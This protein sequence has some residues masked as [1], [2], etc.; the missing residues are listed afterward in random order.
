MNRVFYNRTVGIFVLVTLLATSLMSAA[1]NI[2]EGGDFDK[3]G[4][5]GLPEGPSWAWKN[6]GSDDLKITFSQ[7]EKFS[8]ISS[9]HLLDAN[10][11]KFNDGL[12]WMMAGNR[13]AQWHGKSL[14]LSCM[15]KQIKSSRPKGIGIA[16]WL[17]CKD[18]KIISA[19][20]GPETI[21]ETI[22]QKYE[23]TIDV[24]ENA[25]IFQIFLSCANGWGNDGE[26]YFDELTLKP[27]SSTSV[28]SSDSASAIPQYTPA[29]AF[30]F[31]DGRV[32]PLWR[33]QAWGDLY[34]EERQGVQFLEV[35]T[36]KGS[37]PN[38]GIALSSPY[39]NRVVDL[40]GSTKD[41]E[42][43]LTVKPFMRFQVNLANKS[44]MVDQT[45]IKEVKDGW[46]VVRIPM[47]RFGSGD[48]LKGIESLKIQFP[49]AMAA[50]TTVKIGRI[51]VSGVEK[52]VDIKA[53]IPDLVNQAEQLCKGLDK[54]WTTDD[55]RRP[56]IKNG[57][58]YANDVPVFF[59]GPWI[60]SMLLHADF[61]PGSRRDFLKDDIYNR[62]FDDKIAKNLGVNSFQ[63]SS[64]T[65][66]PSYVELELPWDKRMLENAI[67]AAKLY[68][69]T[70]GMPFILDFAW[71]NRVA[72][73][74]VQ[75]N[76]GNK[77]LLH[78]NTGWHEFIPLC[79]EHQDAIKIYT[80][81][82][83]TGVAFALAN[84]ANPFIYEIFNESSYM[85]GCEFNRKAFA[86]YLQQRFKTVSSI[87]QSMGISITSFE[88]LS[89][90]PRYEV[91]PAL[92]VEWCKFMSRR[93]AAILRQYAK[94][95][96]EVDRRHNVYITEQLWVPSLFTPNGAGMDYRL[97][98]D[99]LDVLTIEGGRHFG[100]LSHNNSNPMEAAMMSPS[101]PFVADFFAALSKGAK[102]VV[103]SEHYC[104]RNYFGK[105]VPS[106]KEDLITAMWSEVF[107]GM[108]GS[109]TYA[110]CKRIWEWKNLKEAK[111]TVYDGGYK[112]SNMLNP[113]SWPREALDGFKVFSGELKNL[114]EIALPQPRQALGTVALVYSYPSLRMSAVNRENI[115]KQ[116]L[117]SY[118][119]LI[120]KQYPVEIVFA[121]DIPKGVLKRFNAVVLPAIR[122]T[123]SQTVES[124]RH[125]VADGGLVVCAGN[126]LSEDEYGRPL[127]ASA[128]LGL[129]RGN[130][131]ITSIGAVK[132]ENWWSYRIGKGS[133]TYI[134]E[135][136]ATPKSAGLISDILAANNTKR[137]FTVNGSSP[138][139]LTQVELRLIDR[140]DT[141]LLL[142][143][144]WEDQ[145]SR[146]VRLRYAGVETLKPM[147]I[148]S[149]VTCDL[150]LNESSDKWDDAT[151][152][153]RG[154]DVIL[155]PQTRVLL[156]LT[157]RITDKS[158]KRVSPQDLNAEF[159]LIQTENA[160]AL[161]DANSQ[162][163]KLQDEYHA[164]R[165]YPD[166][167][168]ADCIPIN[169]ARHV[170]VGFKDELSGDRK[171]GWFDQ[172]SNDYSN[173][174]IG[175]VILAGVPFNIIA[176]ENNQGNSVIVMR[177]KEWPYVSGINDIPVNLKAKNLYILHTAG[178]T[179]QPGSTCYYLMV[180][181]TDGDSLNIP[182]RFDYEIGGWW[183][184][185]PLPYAKIA[186]ETSNAIC[187]RVGLYCW[188]WSNPTPDKEIASI[189]MKGGGDNAVP[190]IVA[191]SAEK[192]YTGTGK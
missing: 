61:G 60:D 192:Y 62:V 111:D 94:V 164:A 40:S 123:D 117:N 58:F 75:E 39:A 23:L 32:L 100:Q 149:P 132:N 34:V 92:W 76:S 8:G 177:G 189:D 174:P 142:L 160:K 186:H 165:K 63:L 129:N 64:A 31:F 190:A 134:D 187:K 180:K 128:L 99:E 115:E 59:L 74:L 155:P 28:K 18:G 37:S 138:Q 163:K 71:V 21:G 113:Y 55:Y 116:L 171:G 29:D 135:T 104:V 11:G 56:T 50:G 143:V 91:I 20:A 145:G 118:F 121:E 43:F 42:L 45:A 89:E 185:K 67:A 14:L 15:I 179:Q 182:V 158:Y 1:D 167:N 27:L 36:V 73:P 169:L 154:I 82:F 119:S 70:Q 103:N 166:V 78:H 86:E 19:F 162:E 156:M 53:V 90:I 87:N 84:G 168:Q 148:S 72:H 183:N 133:V 152:R 96:R 51:G 139:E 105:R 68:R 47:S 140:G 102:P 35:A 7:E 98:A 150:Y 30:Y 112:A 2:I 124:L 126:A 114:A 22:W 65:R 159:K 33:K 153:Q 125:Y 95:I 137:Y 24:P 161:N 12:A 41:S 26:A 49:D 77:P 184:P 88:S 110:W 120:Y 44:L 48:A 66:L 46:T 130:N 25:E 122:N 144:N 10:R 4:N 79:P 6:R 181:F 173:A 101:Y 191:I 13:V 131:S 9:L 85:C 80:S 175:K 147:Y 176:P 151:L 188:K 170:N 38:A 172:G 136:F 157:T 97:I 127:D 3:P 17:K 54:V 146:L 57:V 109:F 69:G 81:Y 107:Y 5:N 16:Y 178:W 52:N 93:Y 108:S 106:K 83:R 141:K